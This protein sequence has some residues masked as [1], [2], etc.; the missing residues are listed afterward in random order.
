MFK[1]Q[2]PII[3]IGLCV[4]IAALVLGW[5]V[6]VERDVVAPVQAPVVSDNDE[7]SENDEIIND[8]SVIEDDT[9]GDNDVSEMSTSTDFFTYTKND[10]IFSVSKSKFK[11]LNKFNALEL[12][13]KSKDC[14]TNKSEQYFKKLLSHYSENDSGMEYQFKYQGQTQDSG[15]WIVTIIPN[16]IGYTNLEDFKNDFNLCEAGSDKYPSLM[17]EKYFLFVSSCGTGYDDDSGLPHGCDVVRK[18]VEPTIMVK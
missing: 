7:N 9:I 17:L 1:K 10:Q 16:K 2:L 15:I 5:T 18:I 3:F 13:N 4:V 6:F 14:G 11:V 12:K 8:S